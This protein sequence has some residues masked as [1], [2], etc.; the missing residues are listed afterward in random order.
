MSTSAC[1]QAKGQL[2]LAA[3]GRLPESERLSLDSHLE[4]CGQCRQELASLSD[5]SQALSAADPERVDQVVEVPDSLRTVV[6]GS[7]ETEAARHRRAWRLRIAAAAAVVVLAVAGSLVAV[8]AGGSHG[9][10]AAHSFAL[11][12]PGGAR[13]TVVLT[14][15]TWGT[16][17][18]LR[19]TGEHAAG[20]LTV[21][22]REDNGSWWA[23][24][25]YRGGSGSTVDVSMSCAVPAS[26]IDAVRVTN[27]AGNQ[28]LGGGY[29]D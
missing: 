5:I 18:H 16:A 17:V 8:N 13:A 6:L 19:A 11:T 12:G 10:P 9:A 4:G 14:A 29:D 20:V 22:M 15:E 25:T 24:G 21:W 1:D 7:L 26:A 28:V 2:A 3:I 27:S 23:A